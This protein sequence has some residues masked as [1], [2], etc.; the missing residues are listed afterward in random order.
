MTVRIDENPYPRNQGEIQLAES[1]VGPVAV[2]DGT[3]P[4]HRAIAV[5]TLP[6]D[7]RNR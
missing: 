7:E 3:L 1:R 2:T 5:M 4:D 6:R